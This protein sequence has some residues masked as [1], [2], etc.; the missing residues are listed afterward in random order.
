VILTLAEMAAAAGGRAAGDATLVPR[1]LAVDSRAVEPGDF[2]VAVKGARQDGHDFLEDVA[3]RGAVGALVSRA[4]SP[5]PAGLARLEVK[6][7][8]QALQALGAANRRKAAARVIGVTGSN[9]KTTTKEMV[10]QMLEHA[11]RRA[12]ATRGNLNSQIG[13]PLMLSELT[14]GHS[15]AVLE[16]G[17]SEKG[18]I[19]RLAAL[20]RPDVGVITGIGAAHL[21]FFGS[22]E[23]VR[24]AK[25]EMVEGLSPEGTA[26]LN[27][28]DALLAEWMPRCP[29]RVVSFGVNAPADVRAENVTADETVSFD[30]VYKGARR[31]VRLPVGG[32]FNVTNALAA[33]AVGLNENLDLAAVAEALGRFQPPALRMEI[34]RRADDVLFV[35]DAY[36][37]NPTSMRASLESF[38]AAYPK[39]RRFA[40]VG[41]MLELGPH[42]EAEHRAL[43][44]LLASLPVDGTF[45]LGPEGDAVK[46]GHASGKT[47]LSVFTDKAAFRAALAET[48]RSGDAVFFKASR[49]VRMEEVFEPLLNGKARVGD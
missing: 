19:A 20:A 2:F 15:H 6:D 10:G 7:T 35:L 39:R 17:A 30:L 46:A 28:D 21:E 5:W 49:G 11:G 23:G 43:G 36:N 26:V 40:A 33:A 3:R 27:A 22:L 16:M 45:F 4:V 42:A 32:R 8:V 31:T 25:W 24:A 13:L 34:R 18:N 38:A 41:S 9:G 47:P 29:R 48:I 14:G 44:K 12:L 37:A 1:R